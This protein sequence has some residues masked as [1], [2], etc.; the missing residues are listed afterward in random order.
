MADV[1]PTRAE[2]VATLAAVWLEPADQASVA[3][4]CH[5]ARCC[6]LFGPPLALVLP[7]SLSSTRRRPRWRSGA[8]APTSSQTPCKDEPSPTSEEDFSP[9]FWAAGALEGRDDAVD[10]ADDVDDEWEL[11]VWNRDIERLRRSREADLCEPASHRCEE[12]VSPG[13]SEAILVQSSCEEAESLCDDAES[14]SDDERE[15]EL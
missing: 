12:E 4:L 15:L 3:G 13:P 2:V 9:E 11:E 14:V 6:Q 5:E 8:L 10:A 1:Q 7:L